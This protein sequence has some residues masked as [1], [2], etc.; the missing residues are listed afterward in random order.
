MARMGNGIM[1]E[2]QEQYIARLRSNIADV[3]IDWQE[4]GDM[5]P[6]YYTQKL[7]DCIMTYKRALAEIK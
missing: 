4:K 2:E 1:T 3:A 6:E 5:E 7:F